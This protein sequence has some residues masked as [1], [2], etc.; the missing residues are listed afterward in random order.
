MLQTINLEN[1]LEDLSEHGFTLI[2]LNPS[3]CRALAKQANTRFKNNVFKDAAV[4]QSVGPNPQIRND[5]T[6]WLDAK[7]FALTPPE[8][9]ILSQLEVV[10]A[11]LRNYFR[12]SLSE[13]ECHYAVYNS[14]HFYQRHSDN[15]RLDNK[16]F[17]SFVIYLNENWHDEDGGQL[18]GYREAK[19]IFKVK[20]EIGQMILFKSDIE[21]EV[22]LAHRQRVSLTGW[23]RK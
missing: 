7:Y 1:H 16:R 9:A 19:I 14:G 17:F 22:S 8:T 15:T 6:L 5:Q 12:V 21:H 3:A 2:P 23:F 13:F 10:M 18:I 20:P 4:S 11:S